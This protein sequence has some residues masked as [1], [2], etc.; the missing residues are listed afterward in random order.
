MALIKRR[1]TE[2]IQQ[3]NRRNAAQ[4]AGPRTAAGK[5]RSRLNALNHGRYSS[6]ATRYF[7][8]WFNTWMI[9]PWEPRRWEVSKMPVP[10]P[11]PPEPETWGGAEMREFLFLV[12]PYLAPQPARHGGPPAQ[13]A[14]A[15]AQTKV[16]WGGKGTKKEFFF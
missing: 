7:R 9:G 2:R 11:P 10:L 3:A 6:L 1:V 14:S 12:A 8:L 5:A 15:S 4:S 13:R 16:L